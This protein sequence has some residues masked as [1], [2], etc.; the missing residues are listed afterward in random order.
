MTACLRSS[1]RR[2]R[3]RR[4]NTCPTRFPRKRR[5][6]GSRVVMDRQ[7]EIQSARNEALVG[8]TFEVLVDGASRRPG[9]WSGRS[10]SNRILN[11]TSPQ[12]NLLGEYVQ[13]RV[14]ERQPQQP[15][16]EHVI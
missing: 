1:I 15:V 2:G 13:V 14:D 3:T 12:E 16:G 11:F 5:A 6:A 4:R 7:R 8:Q 9:Q 10:S